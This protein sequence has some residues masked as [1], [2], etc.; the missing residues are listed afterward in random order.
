[1]ASAPV[2]RRSALRAG[3]GA[4]IAGVTVVALPGAIAAA[5]EGGSSGSGYGGY[6]AQQIASFVSYQYQNTSGSRSL[7]FTWQTTSPSNNVAFTSS[8]SGPFTGSPWTSTASGGTVSPNTLSGWD[9]N[10][11]VSVTLVATFPFTATI[12]FDIDANG[13]TSNWRVDGVPVDNPYG[14]FNGWTS[15]QI[16]NF[17]GYTFSILSSNRRLAFEWVTPDFDPVT[18]TSSVSGP[19]TG[20][21]MPWNATASGGIVSLTT[22]TGWTDGE[23]VNVTLTATAP[24]AAV[25]TFNVTASGSSGVSSDWAVDGGAVDPPG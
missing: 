23:T 8:V 21:S 6:S 22:L 15:Q 9:D 7:G 14:T 19:F 18:Y 4:A 20:P 5:S 13:N 12:T 24:F 16:A 25:V 10:E 11:T 3:G 17:V 2:S 1:M